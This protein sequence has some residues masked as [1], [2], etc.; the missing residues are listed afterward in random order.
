MPHHSKQQNP[1]G[2]VNFPPHSSPGGDN[3]GHY[4]RRTIMPPPGISASMSMPPGSVGTVLG[5]PPPPLHQCL[6][7]Q[8]NQ[9]SWMMHRSQPSSSFYQPPHTTVHQQSVYRVPVTP[10]KGDDS[11]KDGSH[12][13]RSSSVSSSSREASPPLMLKQHSRSKSF[14][15]HHEIAA[16]VLLLASSIRNEERLRANANSEAIEA[17]EDID[18]N[19]AVVG[20]V[21]DGD[22]NRPLKKRKNVADIITMRTKMNHN[23][24]QAYHVSPM[25]GPTSGQT[26]PSLPLGGDEGGP[27]TPASSYDLESTRCIKLVSHHQHSD[28]EATVKDFPLTLHS[29]LSDTE[30]AGNVVRWLPDGKSWKIVRWDALRRQ[31]LPK[32]FPTLN[33]IDAFLSH[34]HI[35]EFTEITD[36]PD[37]GAYTHM[38]SNMF[39]RHDRR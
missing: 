9:S 20:S 7:L 36:G 38:V 8:P 39:F 26:S 23:E 3:G 22:S 11:G 10:L 28:I 2:G 18:D 33:S 24:D 27:N 6:S 17:S 15:S 14:E 1:I 35:W 16:S 29:V 21:Y 19:V 12:L 5:A 30:F 13:L 34:L 31:I 25:S 32:F 4:Y 37:A